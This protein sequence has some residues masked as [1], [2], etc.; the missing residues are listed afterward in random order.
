MILFGVLLLVF[1]LGLLVGEA[2]GLSGGLHAAGGIQIGV[3]DLP[4]LRVDVPFENYEALLTQREEGL[5]SGV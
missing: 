1:V 3:S 4:I 2:G 5:A